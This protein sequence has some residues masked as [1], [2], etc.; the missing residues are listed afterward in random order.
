M[1]RLTDSIAL[2]LAAH[3]LIFAIS[4]C[5]LHTEVLPEVKE[6]AYDNLETLEL[7]IA[8]TPAAPDT[9]VSIRSTTG[10]FSWSKG[11]KVTVFYATDPDNPTDGEWVV[12]SEVKPE[13]KVDVSAPSGK[14]RSKVAIYPP[15]AAVTSAGGWSGNSYEHIVYPAVYDIAGKGDEYAPVPMVARND[16][17]KAGLRFYHAG[18]LMRFNIYAVPAGTEKI[19]ISFTDR[20]GAPLTVT[21]AFKFSYELSD[22]YAT[23]GADDSVTGPVGHGNTVTFNLTGTAA[24]LGEETDGLVINVPVPVC[25]IGGFEIKAYKNDGTTLTIPAGDVITQQQIN[26]AWAW[27]AH[28]ALGL[29]KAVCFGYHPPLNPI[30]GATDASHVFTIGPNK[31]VYIARTDLAYFGESF[32]D[33][34]WRLIEQ[35]WD[36]WSSTYARK[37]DVRKFF[38]ATSGYVPDGHSNWTLDAYMPWNNS[39][40]VIDHPTTFNVAEDYETG[41]TEVFK[42]DYPF[43]SSAYDD[44]ESYQNSGNHTEVF[45]A[46]FDGQKT[47]SVYRLDSKWDWGVYNSQFQNNVNPHPTGLWTYEGKSM[48]DARWR[49]PEYEEMVSL[50]ALPRAI[51]QFWGSTGNLSE[52]SSGEWTG[53]DDY[54]YDW[55]WYYEKS[56]TYYQRYTSDAYAYGEFY[57]DPTAVPRWK[58]DIPSVVFPESYTYDI[59]GLPSGF[60]YS[61]WELNSKPNQH[62]TRDLEGEF[63][64][65]TADDYLLF[66]FIKIRD[67]HTGREQEFVALLPDNWGTVENP[68]RGK[69][70]IGDGGLQLVPSY[71]GTVN[72]AE[73]AAHNVYTKER[74]KFFMEPSGIVLFEMDQNYANSTFFDLSRPYSSDFPKEKWKSWM[75]LRLGGTTLLHN[76]VIWKTPKKAEGEGDNRKE[77]V[78]LIRDAN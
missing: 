58:S 39:Q 72:T 78:R 52:Y 46:V 8:D 71:S 48:N 31:K 37:N 75:A 68:D 65:K 40:F 53:N 59:D 12:T 54:V 13:E 32:P 16:P 77:S 15:E 18:A 28:R 66:T 9:K 23:T 63:V 19:V 51:G 2:A 11:D 7:S 4:S 25:T 14:V 76:L 50:F 42:Q 36:E 38:P 62:S 69:N 33:S 74:W 35:P 17:N 45:D 67:M 27:D 64:R 41:M 1:K 60:R 57:I 47:F 73:L 44:N 30:V 49:V 34:P 21:G 26:N 6:P 61:G 22:S 10:K 24:G 70:L 5:N 20:G 43:L 3:L 55:G 56:G 29:E